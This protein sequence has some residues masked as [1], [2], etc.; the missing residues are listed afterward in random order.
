MAYKALYRAYRPQNFDELAGQGHIVKTL[1]NAIKQNKIA[2]AYLFCGPR[3]T[4]KTTIAK[5]LAKAI[6]CTSQGENIPCNECEN[7]KAINEGTHQDIIEIDAASNNGVDEVRDLIEKVKYAPINGKYKVYIIDEVHMMSTGAF[8][9]LLKTLEEPPTHVVF[10]LA[11]TEPQK[12]LPTIISRCQRFDFGK[13]TENDIIERL[14]KVLEEE[15]IQ[16]EDEAISLIAS[17]A[18]GGMR[19]ALSI[20]EQCLAYSDQLTLKDVNE[21]YGIVSVPQKIEFIRS[22]MHKDIPSILRKIEEMFETGIDI[23]RLTID[24]I[25]ILKDIV[26][27][28]NTN[29]YDN[30]FILGKNNIQKIV[31]YITIEETFEFIDILIQT[32]QQ[33]K[34]ASNTKL[35]FELATLKIANSVKNDQKI[36]SDT[37]YIKPEVNILQTS[38]QPSQVEKITVIKENKQPPIQKENEI[39]EEKINQEM[40]QDQQEIINEENSVIENNDVNEEIIDAVLVEEQPKEIIQNI[41]VDFNDLL[42]ILVQANRQILNAIQE[43]WSVIKRYQFN[44]NT[45]KYASMLCDGK[46]VAASVGGLVIAFEYQPSVNQINDGRYY[47][48]LK[49]FLKEVLSDDYD[50]IAIL[51]S[52]W[53][54]VRQKFIELKKS[55][56]LPIPRPIHLSHIKEIKP[57]EE[58]KQ[59]SEAEK[60]GLEL[61]GDI[62]EIKEN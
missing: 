54:N 42:N 18:D 45:A 52:E 10:I 9:A 43:K 7:C 58:V 12:I 41:E 33:Y 56:Q 55:N 21:I 38:T 51:A 40:I 19:D 11:T 2:H 37:T 32:D 36:A 34:Y 17:L 31:P 1:K 16:C 24:L 44:L 27:F 61:F 25:D 46:V 59:Y 53:P 14:K 23:K 28:K 15:N 20:L 5:I 13:I 30:L 62:V 48:E 39:K 8:N 57:E 26:I 3:G 35:Y 22:L 47:Y 60:F 6:N 4:G 50:F 49:K 29:D